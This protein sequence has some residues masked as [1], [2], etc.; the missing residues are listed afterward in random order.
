MEHIKNILSDFNNN[1]SKD[2]L[3]HKLNQIKIVVDHVPDDCCTVSKEQLPA[4]VNLINNPD[5]FSAYLNSPFLRLG[6]FEP[7]VIYINGVYDPVSLYLFLR[8]E[9]L[10]ITG[11]LCPGITNA[12]MILNHIL[13]LESFGDFVITPISPEVSF[14]DQNYIQALGIMNQILYYE[15][16]LGIKNSGFLDVERNFTTK[17]GQRS[18]VTLHFD[19][20]I[21]DQY[22]PGSFMI[23]VKT[24]EK[25]LTDLLSNTTK[26]DQ[27]MDNIPNEFQ[28][29]ELLKIYD[30]YLFRLEQYCG[31]DWI[32]DGKKYLNIPISIMRVLARGHL[33]TATLMK[34]EY[35]QRRTIPEQPVFLHTS[36]TTSDTPTLVQLGFITSE[37]LLPDAVLLEAERVLKEVAPILING[38]TGGVINEA[39]KRLENEFGITKDDIKSQEVRGEV[40]IKMDNSNTNLT[41]RFFGS[42]APFNFKNNII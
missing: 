27:I 36:D 31:G 9:I 14:L 18:S 6:T 7:S 2:E 39:Y 34:R 41:N 15:H 8:R 35:I 42:V 17:I 33:A 32:V 26:G 38:L 16:E 20:Y 40:T 29:L 24:K 4:L 30:E 11:P 13:P 23:N 3:I 5:N 12:E 19:K 22:V 10:S 28:A 25:V 21:I 1:S 37:Y